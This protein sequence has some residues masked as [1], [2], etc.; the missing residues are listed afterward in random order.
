M[1]LRGGSWNNNQDNARAVYRND[2]NPNNRNNDI[3]F[4]V[5]SVLRPTPLFPFNGQRPRGFCRS[6]SFDQEPPIPEIPVG[7][8]LPVAAEA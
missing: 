1:H 2:N 8:A 4:R 7:Y 3:G 5:V 6:V